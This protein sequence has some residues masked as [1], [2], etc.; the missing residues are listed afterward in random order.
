M[1]LLGHKEQQ[2][3]FFLLTQSGLSIVVW[4]VITGNFFFVCFDQ[5]GGRKKSKNNFW[6]LISQFIH[7]SKALI[8]LDKKNVALIFLWCDVCSINSKIRIIM[9]TLLWPVNVTYGQLYY[10]KSMIYPRVFKWAINVFSSI[11]KESHH[12]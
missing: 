11:S 7:Q 1:L 12:K 10:F 2:I 5:K 6:I 9:A 4:I 8:E 3:T